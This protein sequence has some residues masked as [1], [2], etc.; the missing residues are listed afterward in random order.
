MDLASSVLRSAPWRPVQQRG[1]GGEQK[2]QSFPT[3]AL[4]EALALGMA[5]LRCACITHF[6]RGVVSCCPKIQLA[7]APRQPADGG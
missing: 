6:Y 1:V 4:E 2:N 3:L 7:T 5:P